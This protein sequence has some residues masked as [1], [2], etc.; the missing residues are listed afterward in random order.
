MM[1]SNYNLYAYDEKFNCVQEWSFENVKL[2]SKDNTISVID[3]AGKVI[4]MISTNCCTV[5]IMEG[6][7]E[8]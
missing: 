8:L 6:D 5:V 4:Y 3:K 1:Y 7:E 2:E